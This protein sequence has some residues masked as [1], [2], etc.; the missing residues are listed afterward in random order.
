M[1]RKEAPLFFD[2]ECVSFCYA[3]FDMHF[4]GTP[5][6]RLAFNLWN[7]ICCFFIVSFFLFLFLLSFLLVF[8]THILFALKSS[9]VQFSFLLHLFDRDCLCALLALTFTFYDKLI[10]ILSQ[11]SNRLESIVR[12][13]LSLIFFHCLFRFI[14]LLWCVHAS[15][16]CR[17]YVS[18]V[19]LFMQFFEWIQTCFSKQKQRQQIIWNFCQLNFRVQERA[20]F[21]R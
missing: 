8:Y 5:T 10:L 18:W 20:T 16:F 9:F 3:I 14:L 11:R 17:R 15:G 2:G 7:S 6:L 12:Y 21:E 19:I 13:L 4:F 1:S